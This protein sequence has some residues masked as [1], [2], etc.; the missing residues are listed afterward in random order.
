PRARGEPARAADA[1]RPRRDPV[2]K[3]LHDGE[4]EHRAR[5]LDGPGGHVR[6][7]G[8][9]PAGRT[10]ARMEGADRPGDVE[11]ARDRT[12]DVVLRDPGIR[13]VRNSRRLV[14]RGHAPPEGG[15]PSPGN[16]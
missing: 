2:L 14:G 10:E 4:G 5:V 7:R 16:R 3:R 1:L 9:T 6:E 8:T 15:R 11:G 13:R 12:V